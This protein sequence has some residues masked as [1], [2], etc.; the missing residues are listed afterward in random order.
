MKNMKATFWTVLM[1]VCL[2]A[3]YSCGNMGSGSKSADESHP[4]AGT[5]YTETGIRF[6]LHEDST[7][8]I[9]FS[10][11]VTYESTWKACKSDDNLEYANIEFAGN[12]EFYYLRKGKLYRSE[13]EMRHETMGVEVK[14][15]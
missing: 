14:Y 13:R 6:E 10:D 15:Q 11:S 1:I 5:F 9:T 4:F 2:S 12:Q 8:L 7:T 3:L